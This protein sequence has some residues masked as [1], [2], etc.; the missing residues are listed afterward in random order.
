MSEK[1]TAR[2]DEAGHVYVV[3]ADGE[4]LIGQYADVSPEE[5]LAFFERKF[6]DTNSALV[7]LEQRAKRGAPAGEIA[8]S[9][10]KIATQIE[11]RN[12]I[13]N[14]LALAERL[15][16]LVASLSELSE[17]EKEKSAL[18]AEASRL[19]RVSIVEEIESLASTDPSKIQWKTTTAKVEELFTRW[20]SEQKSGPRLSKTE[21]NELWKRFRDARQ[22]LDQHRRAFFA[23]LDSKNKGAKSA[24]EDLISKAENLQE[25]GSNG[26]AAYRTLLD[27][28]KLAPRA[29][30]K[31]DDALW[32]RFKTAGDALYAAKKEQDEVEDASFAENLV[33]K[34][35]IL[36]EAETL[37]DATDRVDARAKLN[38]FQ[39][40]WDAAGKVPRAQLKTTEER[41]RKVEQAVRKLEDNFWNASN[42][43]K[44]ARSE[45]LAGQLEEKIEKLELELTAAQAAKDNKKVLDIQESIKIQKEWLAVLK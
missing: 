30:K 25:Q 27:Q 42:P 23:E 3:E 17:A 10:K 44:Q 37:I 21:S 9:A 28:W 11:T 13:G 6:N 12:G 14:Y 45:G 19:A 8:E 41:M 2:V 32:A 39:K 40:K 18:V 1:T 7:L 20:Q 26:V 16:K 24:K 43:E 33:A 22:K 5:A 31:I 29:G 38:S 36:S 35:A 34:L 4:R 15:D